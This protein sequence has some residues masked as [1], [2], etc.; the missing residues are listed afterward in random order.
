MRKHLKSLLKILL[1]L[2]LGGAIL[3]VTYRDFDFSSVGQVLFHEMSLSWM[4]LSLVFEVM[5]HVCRG[6]RWKQVLAPL[7]EQPRTVNCINAIF[8]SYASSLIIPRIG[9]V[10]RCGVLTRY[11]NVSFSKSLGTV[12]TERVVDM[13]CVALIATT[14][15][16]TQLDTFKSFFQRTGSNL[17]S[18]Q[19]LLSSTEFYLALATIFALIFIAVV[20]LRKLSFAEKVKSTARNLWEGIISVRKVKNLP[21]FLFLSFAVWGCYIMQFYLTFYCFGFT[22]HLGFGVGL[23]AFVLGSFAVLIPTPNGAGPWH[24]AIISMLV[25]YGVS[26]EDAG[27]FALLVHGIQ[28]FVMIGLGIYGMLSL[29]II[30]KRKSLTQGEVSNNQAQ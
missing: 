11:D 27:I 16:L 22:E 14:A 29:L 5:S 20:I 15:L 2:A 18:I 10:L 26:Q 23:S 13:V 4:M 24:Y 25:L 28:T 6:L 8:I 3:Y 30:G 21:L 19:E 17:G 9:E 1:P 7:G 12:V